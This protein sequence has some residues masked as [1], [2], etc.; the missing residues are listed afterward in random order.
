[1]M[2]P[3]LT[4]SL[5]KGRDGA[6]GVA[7]PAQI[8]R[9]L[10]AMRTLGQAMER[11]LAARRGYPAM[12][13]GRL[14]DSLLDQGSFLPA[15]DGVAGFGPRKSPH[16][17]PRDQGSDALHLRHPLHL[18]GA[19]LKPHHAQL[20]L[21]TRDIAALAQ[22]LSG[23]IEAR[24]GCGPA[25]RGHAKEGRQAELA[26]APDLRLDLTLSPGLVDPLFINSALRGC[27]LDLRLGLRA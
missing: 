7:L 17:Q 13:A 19:V 8:M 23:L 18:V 14:L 21:P 26:I 5:F 22:A 12:L 4:G 10:Q 1:M 24:L 20:I 25:W 11:G 15:L 3:L 2:G 6:Q 16:P 27:V 9:P